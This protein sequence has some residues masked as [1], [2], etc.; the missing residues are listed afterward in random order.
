MSRTFL[1]TIKSIMNSLFCVQVKEKYKITATSQ[2]KCQV[3]T[4]ALFH[5]CITIEFTHFNVSCH[6]I[7]VS[8][9]Y[10]ERAPYTSSFIPQWKKEN[11][12]MSFQIN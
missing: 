6:Q 10:N 9:Q 8:I 5:F 2:D 11:I 12:A 3:W 7:T 1:F 4:F